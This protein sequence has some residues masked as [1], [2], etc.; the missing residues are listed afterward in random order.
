VLSGSLEG[1]PVIAAPCRPFTIRYDVKNAG[2][3]P[4]TTGSV[5]VEILSRNG[6]PAYAKQ[7]T[8]SLK[9]QSLTIEKVNLPRGAYTLRL[10]ASA[11]NE[12]HRL[13]REFTLAEQVVT[14]AGPVQVRKA[15]SAVPRVL[16]WRGTT[17]N[18]LERALSETIVKQAFEDQALY[19]KVVDSADE[20]RVQA[21]RGL[22]NVFVLFEIDEAPGSWE[23]L[24]TLVRQG[25]SLVIIGE[26][27]DTGRA[28][29][30]FG[31][32]FDEPL[33]EQQRV[34][35]LTG[36]A[37]LEL[38]GTIPVS[39]R[40]LRPKK[41][42]AQAVAFVAGTDQA[43]ALVDRSEKGTVALLPFSFVR[44]ARS[45]GTNAI[46][47]LTL[48]TAIRSLAPKTDE[49]GG[50]A[51]RELIVSSATGPVKAKIIVTL[52]QGARPLWAGQAGAVDG[53]VITFQF[54]A[55]RDE[56]SLLYLYDPPHEAGEKPVHAVFYD[57]AGS[58]VSQEGV[59]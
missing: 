32:S 16:V 26:G 44:S 45:C 9:P 50:T 13:T 28:A 8:L 1:T 23:W 18:T 41:K 33:R 52:P 27:D 15:D 10:S 59:E 4:A 51:S 17:M 14:I 46:Y 5:K 20:F 37:A 19:V 42:A 36:K 34:L 40:M 12:K 54:T 22:F 6:T 2:T 30:A 31:Y 48:R 29:E 21:G 56:Q 3:V 57:C 38:G 24:R 11:A 39:G 43:G 25:Q 7:L 53:S 35:T 49:A 55:G 58:Y 47:S